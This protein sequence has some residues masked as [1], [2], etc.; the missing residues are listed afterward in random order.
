MANFSVVTYQSEDKQY[1]K[2]AAD[3][4]TRIETIVDTKAIYNYTIVYRASEDT[5]VGTLVYAA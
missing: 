5:F 2:V 3:L 1:Q 4:E